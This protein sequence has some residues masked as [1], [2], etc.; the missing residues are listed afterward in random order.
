MDQK[1]RESRR[2]F[3]EW[4][5]YSCV[6]VFVTATSFFVMSWQSWWT[7]ACLELVPRSFYVQVFDG[8]IWVYRRPEIFQDGRGM[9]PTACLPDWWRKPNEYAKHYFWLPGIEFR[10]LRNDDDA[11]SEWKFGISL[12]IVAVATLVGPC[13]L[14][15][16][17]APARLWPKHSETPT[18]T[19]GVP[20]R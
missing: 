16:R 11:D 14:Y 18:P 7:N 20:S 19:D 9:R 8:D 5:L 12:I 2:P 10:Y 4:A 15:K 13:V 6:T 1:T 17:I 3:S